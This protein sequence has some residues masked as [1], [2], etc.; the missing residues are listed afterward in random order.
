[1]TENVVSITNAPKTAMDYALAY[2]AIGWH[3]FPVWGA[4][5]G[6]CKCRRQC[7]SPAKHPVEYLVPKGQDNATTDPATIRSWW[8]QMPT[9]GVAVFLR[10]S[11]LVA[12]DIDPRNG[13]LDTIDEIEAK[14]GRLFSDV[15][16][17]TQAGGEHRVFKLAPGE[18]VALPGK[19]G[20]GVD[21]KRNGYIVLAPTAGVS[22]IYDWEASSNPIEGNIPTPLPDWI[23][24]MA[25]PVVVTEF[26]APAGN[27]FVTDAQV[28]ELREA[29]SFLSSDERETWIRYGMALSAIG[30][31]GWNL[32]DE[33][34]RKSKKY[35]PVDSMRVWRSFK[36][37][38]INFESIFF[39]AQQAGWVNPLAGF[40][41]AAE[42]EHVPLAPAPVSSV[43]EIPDR[44]LSPPGILGEVTHWIN[45]T[46]RKPQPQFA[47]QAAIAFAATVM[48]RRY[49]TDQRNW[50]SLFLLNI[51]KSASGKEHGKWAVEHLLEACNLDKLI[52][53]ANYTSNSGVLSALH[54]QPSHLT[55][56]DE[57]GKVLEAASVKH[58]ARAAS[59]MTALMEVWARCDGVMRP[60]GYSTFGMSD[61]DA[62]K[63]AERAVR[64]P[65]LTLLAMT[66]PE[67]FFE[68]IGSAAARDGFLNRF[69][70][71]E[72]DIGRQVGTQTGACKVPASI[73]EWAT[74]AHKYEGLAN[75]DMAPA[76]A[77]VPKI[78]HIQ[79][80]A[81]ALFA[82][83]E[84]E[85][86]DLMNAHDEAGLA[87][88]FGRCNEIAMKLSLV[89]AV[90]D[91]WTAVNE[92]HA[93]WA[94]DYVRFYALRT[95][96]RLATSVADS[97]FEAV[98]QKVLSAILAAGRNGLAEWELEKKCNAFRALDQRGQ[99]NA[100]NSLAFVS[101]IQR[102][103][104]QK[105]RG[106]PRT[107]WV[108][109]D[110]EMSNSPEFPEESS[111]N[112]TQ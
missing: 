50:P 101:R 77:A 79:K 40:A 62:A 90:G 59:A 33:W 22:G 36:P 87:E 109:I 68:T 41:P 32:W 37:G 48:G 27:R 30:Q 72:S 42:V 70:I 51:G 57:F 88:M 53:P 97:E 112:I 111:G 21:L 4:S 12:V 66:T 28:G 81:A 78:V 29:L 84:A 46:S 108:A 67:S 80:K 38:A 55:V 44:L 65:A 13:G 99:I 96:E 107:A 100:L 5:E 52:G 89:V 1:M 104:I 8:S 2:A 43:S 82:A 58:S 45:Q 17:F 24:D 92:D 110:P 19:L 105:T 34:S 26:A 3:V 95:V 54:K 49:C 14:H 25:K 98:K 20:P 60:Q 10:P 69:L 76:L 6:K 18:Q 102:V 16:Q 93:A 85:C 61:A 103:T 64:N 7:S 47:V 63:I 74:Q 106:K 91:G 35:D 39:E 86:I 56:I 31:A 75:P 23:R 15:T 11:G 94:I 71:V 73:I 9:A 83:F